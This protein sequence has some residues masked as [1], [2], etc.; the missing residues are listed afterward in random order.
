MINHYRKKLARRTEF[1]EARP[2]EEVPPE[3]GFSWRKYGKKLVQNIP[4]ECT[5]ILS[6]LTKRY[7]M[8]VDFTYDH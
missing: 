7:Y 2:G 5:I 1:V 6:S 8:R 3:D 4:G